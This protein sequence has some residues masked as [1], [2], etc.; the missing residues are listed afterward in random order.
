[1]ASA[2]SGV[3]DGSMSQTA[4]DLYDLLNVGSQA[5]AEEIRNGYLT[6]SRIHHPDK[7]ALPT[8]SAAFLNINRAYKVLSDPTLREFYDKY[9]PDATMLAEQEYATMA[10]GD[11]QL[12]PAADKLG[13]LEKRVRTLIRASEELATQRFLQPSG[14]IA[15]GTR[16]MSYSPFYHSWSHSSANFGVSLLSGKHSIALYSSSH[17]QRG[18][19][20]I[21][22]ASLILGTSFT[23]SVTSRAMVHL[24]GGRWPVGELMVQKTISEETVVRQTVMLED[25][26]KKGLAVSTEWIQQLSAVLVGTLGVTMGSTRGAS[27]EV[28]KKAGGGWLEKWRGKLRLGLSSSG[29]LSIGGKAKFQPVTG[30]E[31]HVGPQLSAAGQVSFE[32]AIQKELPPV[33]EEQEGAFPTY[34]N[35]SIGLQYPDELTVG[36]KLS[37]GGFSFHFPIELPAVESRW[38]LIG[39][40]AAW[41]FAPLVVKSGSHFVSSITSVVTPATTT[42]KPDGASVGPGVSDEGAAERLALAGEAAERRKREESIRGLV[43]LS[44]TYADL[45]VTD[46]LM[47]R[48]R[49]SALSLSATS[50][51]NLVGIRHPTGGYR[52]EVKYR[53]GEKTYER[54]FSDTDLVLLP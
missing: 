42:T 11:A 33:V 25:V 12:V 14:S 3:P 45:D 38:V 15:M 7:S 30:L 53:Y 1:M 4:A 44:A 16:V 24:M 46:V 23:P 6:M 18:G 19:A 9:G 32:L 13:L 43:I 28:A 37:R 2:S 10:S 35:W 26:G 22:R 52:L 20:A 50:K 49:D 17:T 48:V 41:T 34:L 29:D 27:V 47:A 39:V 40:L 54:S 5:S 51:A 31:L 21:T 36:I 8:S